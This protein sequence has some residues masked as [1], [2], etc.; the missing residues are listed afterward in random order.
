MTVTAVELRGACVPDGA[1][2]TEAVLADCVAPL[3]RELRERG[4]IQGHWFTHEYDAAGR[5]VVLRL[6]PVTPPEMGDVCRL[7]EAAVTRFG[8]RERV[9]LACTDEERPWVFPHGTLT[10]RRGPLGHRPH[11]REPDRYGGEAGLA[12]AEWHFEHSSDLVLELVHTADLRQR[13]TMLGI[14][15]QLTMIMVA[16]FLRTGPAMAELLSAHPGPL[17]T[18]ASYHRVRPALDRRFTEVRAA[19]ETEDPDRLDGFRAEWAWHCDDLRGRVLKAGLPVADLLPTFLA[20]T[21]NRLGLTAADR[22]HL[23]HLLARVLREQDR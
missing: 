2:G 21:D 23:G 11:R 17:P 7:A 19:V 9:D 5:I 6:T 15:A 10:T 22:A 14:S 1:R 8:G 20:A 3:V 4:L 12:I 18:D 16:T 13:S